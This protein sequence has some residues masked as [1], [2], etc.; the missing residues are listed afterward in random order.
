TPNA[1]A[2][3]AN[4]LSNLINPGIQTF[5]GFAA[6]TVAPLA[7]TFPNGT[8]ATLTGGGSVVSLADGTTNGAGRYG[9]TGDADADERFWNSTGGAN[10]LT[11]TFSTPVSAF[12]FFGVDIGDFNGQV[13]VT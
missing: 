8:T 11:L 1:D 3:Q 9:G 12:G 13:T 4:F 6:G 10:A 2:A 5:E 7:V